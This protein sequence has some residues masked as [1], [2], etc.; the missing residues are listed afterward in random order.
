MRSVIATAVVCLGFA[1]AAAAQSP[2]V[3][4]HAKKADK[5][6]VATVEDVVPRY[7]VNEFGDR[8]IVSEVWLRVE[9]TLK[10]TPQGL[11]SMDVEGGTIGDVT[12][13]VSDLPIL[14]RGER[15]VFLM[16]A[17]GAGKGRPHGRGAGILKLDQADRVAGTNLRLAD[18]RA[19]VKASQK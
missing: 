19:S 3:A 7:A 15:G 16:D 12:L 5:V 6:V 2:D 14:R 4:A 9:E 1:A 10:G 18:V 17:A 13:K 8:L 11:V